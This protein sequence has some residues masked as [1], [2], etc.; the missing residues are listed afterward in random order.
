VFGLA[1]EAQALAR[2]VLSGVFL[3]RCRPGE[4]IEDGDRFVLLAD[5]AIGLY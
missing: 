3:L 5:R 2:F 4:R 1:N